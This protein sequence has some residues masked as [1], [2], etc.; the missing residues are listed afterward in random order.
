MPPARASIV[1]TTSTSVALSSY[2]PNA[3]ERSEGQKADP[4]VAVAI[5][6]VSNQA[7]AVGR[8]KDSE[9]PLLAVEP[10]LPGSRKGRFERVLVAHSSEAT[11]LTQL[12][13]ASAAAQRRA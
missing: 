1:V 9:V 2:P 11:V 6:V 10:L 12:V 4:L 5:W 3:E 7:K 8:G 13:L